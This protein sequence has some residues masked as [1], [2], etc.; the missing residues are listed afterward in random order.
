MVKTEILAEMG[1]SKIVAKF[2]LAVGVAYFN[3]VICIIFCTLLRYIKGLRLECN[4][5]HTK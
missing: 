1:G 4:H 5:M 3:E 2:R